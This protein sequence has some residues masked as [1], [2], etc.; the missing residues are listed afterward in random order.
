MAACKGAA[1]DNIEVLLDV[2]S[3]LLGIVAVVVLVDDQ[4]AVVDSC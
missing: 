4:F 3:D 2:D 1:E